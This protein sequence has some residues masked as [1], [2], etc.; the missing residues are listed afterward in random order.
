MVMSFKAGNYLRFAAGLVAISI[1]A[2]AFTADAHV[3]P[4]I[5]STSGSALATPTL[6]SKRKTLLWACS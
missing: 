6:S 5:A 4:D 3:A 2:D 1:H